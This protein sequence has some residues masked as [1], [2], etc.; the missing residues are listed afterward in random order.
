MSVRIFRAMSKSDLARKVG[1][2]ATTL[3]KWMKEKEKHQLIETLKVLCEKYRIDLY[4]DE[5]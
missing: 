3:R 2:S 5:L 1:I 4:E